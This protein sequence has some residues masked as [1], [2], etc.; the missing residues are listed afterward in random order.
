M[1]RKIKPNI[2]ILYSVIF[3]VAFITGGFILQYNTEQI[4]QRSLALNSRAVESFHLHN[5]VQDIIKNVIVI[6]SKVRGFVITG[7]ED[8]IKGVQD[9]LV[10]LKYKL[11][12]LQE[13]AHVHFKQASFALLASLID[14]KITSTNDIITTY[15]RDG[16]TAAQEKVGGKAVAILSDSI[17]DLS[18]Q[19]ENELYDQ[20]QKTLLQ[21]KRSSN[22]VLTTSR[23]LTILS[24]T[25]IILLTLWVVRHLKRQHSLILE[26]E[27]AN[28][29]ETA[30]RIKIE[31]ISEEIQDLYNNAPC[32][33]HSLDGD[34]RFVA[35]NDTEL[36][37]LGYTREEVVGRLF[38]YDVLD[39]ASEM[40]V[41][42][43]FPS[44]KK[45]GIVKERRLTMITKSGATFPILLNSIAVFDEA[46]NYVSSRST[47]F[48]I[49]EQHKIET[50]LKEAKQQA[51][52]SAIIKEQF[53]ANMSHEIRTPINSVIGFTNLLQKTMLNQD[54]KQFVNLIQSASESLL[55]IINDIL[56][57][58]KMEA[59]MLRIERH[60][61][62]LRGLC[63]S[64][65]TMFYH[66]A[67]EKNL[68]F[69]IYIQENIPDTLTGDA[70][71]LT[72]VLV[73]LI[74]NAIK[75]TQKGGININIT[76]VKTNDDYAR[77]RFSVKDSGIGIPDD[78]LDSVFERFQQGETDT[79][80][81]YGGTGLG[82]TIVKNLI[83]MQG[84]IITVESEPGKGT[85]FV[86]EIEYSILPVGQAI[87]TIL[88]EKQEIGTATFPDAK[89]LVVE[90]NPMNQLLIKYTFQSWQI[91]FEVADNGQKAIEWL[92]Q[93]NF[94]LV[95]LD[96]QMP[97]MDGYLTA[98]TIRNEL[99]NDIPIIAMTAHAMAGEREKCLSYG[100]ND[101][102]SKPIHEKELYT[103]LKKYLLKGNENLETLK[104][105]LHYIDVNFLHDMVMGNGEF[106]KTI[107]KQFLKQFPG[108]MEALKN[109]IDQYDHRQVASLSHHIQSTVSIMGKNTPFFQ[110]L[111][112]LEKLAKKNIEP[113]TLT[114]EFNKL[115]DYKQQLLQ[116][117]NQLLNANAF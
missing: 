57:I 112:K 38:I 97:T 6:E 113:A 41:R 36:K 77:L 80:R 105:D 60:P 111:E 102:I 65:E 69:S 9:T 37:W 76:S 84:G 21:N 85:E 1:K 103:L 54:Q 58:S 20:L 98:Q 5:Q 13:G 47:I 7:D 70:V 94:D 59:G 99:K 92:Q 16:K 44:F 15:Y 25:G 64:V 117:V 106:L 68:S 52:E 23:L 32:G 35:M 66:R 108:E 40:I 53:L 39:E 12:S 43:N 89:I 33:Y 115:H 34:A 95:L 73:N 101:Y 93:D 79:T 8:F 11:I 55:T 82:L 10:Q 90:D 4:T 49:T 104:D 46:G 18:R 67:R 63:N 22:I 28:I 51:D 24:L 2:L 116:E 96:I 62:S 29:N 14:K 19:L 100:M 87:P 3:S 17:L 26:L 75:F 45:R 110:Q 91:N 50:A 83:N 27:Q 31:K 74:S 114:A 107:I 78:K 88:P 86:F 42:E 81:K 109:A 72:Q 71:R 56:D 30:T 61:F 48:D